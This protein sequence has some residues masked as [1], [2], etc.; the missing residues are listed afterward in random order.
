MLLCMDSGDLGFCV[1]I[2][3]FIKVAESDT[4][5]EKYRERE[6]ER[7]REGGGQGKRER[8]GGV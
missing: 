3:N 8:K 7:E 2:P 1:S 4:H 5:L 6:R